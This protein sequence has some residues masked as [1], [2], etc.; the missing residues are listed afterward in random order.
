M[1]ASSQELHF[2]DAGEAADLAAFLARLIHYDR[3]AAVRLQAGG[4]VLA[5]FGRPPSFE[6]LAI[7]TARLEAV[8]STEDTPDESDASATSA[9]A[10]GGSGALDTTVSAGEFADAL[11]TARAARTADGSESRERGLVVTVPQAVTGPPWAGVLPP[12]GGWRRVN[13]LPGVNEVRG[14]VTAA[15]AEFRA[16]DAALPEERRTRAERDRIGHEIWSRTLG[17]T[18]LPLR[19]VHAAQSLGFLRPVR[20]AAPAVTA[21]GSGVATAAPEPLALLAAGGWL[22]LRTPYGSIAVR[23]QGLSGGLSGLSVT[24]A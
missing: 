8:V 7:R 21:H 19:A 4:G 15:V 10:A 20:A 11:D 6:V 24:P 12:R 23:T 17:D 16:R 2:A 9:G 14:A 1:T 3:A 18:G 5:V 22:R 13:G